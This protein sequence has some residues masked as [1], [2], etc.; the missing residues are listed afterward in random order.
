[1]SQN[2]NIF[3]S[4][5]TLKCPKCHEG[6]M[7]CNDKI[8]QYKGFFNMPDYCTKCNQDFQLEAGF[9]LGAMFVSYGLTV[10]LNIAVFVAFLIFDAYSLFPYLIT[11]GIVLILTGPFI[12]KISRSIWIALT[13]HYD[14]NAIKDYEAQH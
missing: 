3:K 6:N 7:F 1:M 5:L 9:Y 4:V 14:P 10:A 13:I 12:I 8:Y 11:A 2:S